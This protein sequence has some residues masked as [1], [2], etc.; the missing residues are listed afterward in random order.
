[1]RYERLREFAGDLFARDMVLALTI[2]IRVGGW[3]HLFSG[4]VCDRA[5]RALQYWR[6]RADQVARAGRM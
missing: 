3:V 6:A 4:D 1:M 2:V 5:G